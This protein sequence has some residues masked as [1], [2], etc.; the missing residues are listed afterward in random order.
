MIRKVLWIIVGALSTVNIVLD[1]SYFNIVQPEYLT[2]EI[3][4]LIFKVGF[5]LVIGLAIASLLAAI[6]FKNL[7]YK[8]KLSYLLPA[9]TLIIAG[10]YTFSTATLAY[11]KEVR[12]K[13][14]GPITYYRNVDPPL[15]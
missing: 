2:A 12:G 9:L 5:P 14:I 15:N 4:E 1:Y 10:L 8:Y 6:P 11:Y 7:E 13:D 3:F